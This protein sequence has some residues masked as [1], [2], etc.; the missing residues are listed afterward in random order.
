MTIPV[1]GTTAERTSGFIPTV[2][3]VRPCKQIMLDEHKNNDFITSIAERYGTLELELPLKGAAALKPDADGVPALIGL[4]RADAPWLEPAIARLEDQ[5]HIQLWA[6]RPWVSLRPMLLVGP[7]GCGKSTLAR[8]I[9]RASCCGYATL[10]LGGT[11]DARTIEGTARGFTNAQPCFAAVTIA[12]TR[13][14]NPI[15]TLEEV[16]KAGANRAHG[17]PL[18]V[19]LTQVERSSAEVYYDKCLMA[20]VDLSHV[21]WVLTANA[22][23]RLPATLLSRLDVVEVEGPGGEHFGTVL[24]NVLRDLARRWRV[25]LADLPELQPEVVSRLRQVL[26]RDRSARRLAKLVEHALGAVARHHRR[27]RH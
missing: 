17:D 3:Y 11:S 21:N 14:A 18:A 23:N 26:E 2:E 9:A 4:L 12:Q 22:A 7:P 24:A 27:E 1:D 5:L 13:C 6:G 10:D 25:P 15:I 8:T 20:E 19:L 16:D